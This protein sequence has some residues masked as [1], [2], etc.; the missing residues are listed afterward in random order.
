MGLTPEEVA[1]IL[2]VLDQSQF[3]DIEIETP[4]LKISV[5]RKRKPSWSGADPPPAP[6]VATVAAG[7]VE[8]TAPTPGMFYRAPAPGASPF[9]EVGSTVNEDTV[10][11]I[12][13]VMKLVN[14]IPAGVRGRIVQI[15]AEN[16]QM[17]REG[18]VLFKVHP[19]D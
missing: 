18:Q 16:G 17:V 19:G 6:T 4:G 11:C 8:I 7:V 15:S 1:E 10:V 12:V 2:R 5:Q 13:E 3:D 14:P 9:V